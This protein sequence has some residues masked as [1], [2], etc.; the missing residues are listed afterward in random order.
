MKMCLIDVETFREEF[1]QVGPQ[2]VGI[3]QQIRPW[4]WLE[5]LE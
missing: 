1:N 4:E 2:K 5:W 3:K